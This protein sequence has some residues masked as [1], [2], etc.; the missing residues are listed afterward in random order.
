MVDGK[1]QI[2][3]TSKTVYAATKGGKDGNV[4]SLKAKQKLLLR[5]V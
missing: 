4:T 1:V 2:L 3:A 5:K